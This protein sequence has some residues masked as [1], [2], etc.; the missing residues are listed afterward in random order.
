LLVLSYWREE[1]VRKERSI[2]PASALGNEFGECVRYI[3]VCNSTVD[4]FKNPATAMKPGLVGA[5]QVIKVWRELTKLNQLLRLARST[6]YA[7]RSGSKRDH[8]HERNFRTSSAR[9]M[10]LVKMSVSRPWR[11]SPLKYDAKGPIP[12][13][14][15]WSA[16]Y[17]STCQSIIDLEQETIITCMQR[18]LQAIVKSVDVLY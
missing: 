8:R 18:M 1:H 16:I 7:K 5:N 4:I 12:R 9:Y 2:K 17:L 11:T 14:S 13:S 10:L 6:E 3:S 15:F